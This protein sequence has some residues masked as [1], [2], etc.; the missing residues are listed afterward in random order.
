MK[1]PEDVF[2]HPVDALVLE[3]FRLNGA[4]L[5]SGDALTR[6]LGL[7]SARWQV[8]GAVAGDGE[9]ATVSRIARGMGLARQSVQ[10]VVDDLADAGLVAL[11]DNPHHKRARLVVLTDEGRRRFAAAGA[12]WTP[13]AEL[14]AG[15]VPADDLA[16][17][18]LVLRR[19]RASLERDTEGGA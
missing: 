3:V 1:K 12:A 6:P 4:L 7:T 13:V 2:S 5:A 9:G 11:E 8:L 10:R 17:T 14:L 16:Q 19:L 18:V 15:L